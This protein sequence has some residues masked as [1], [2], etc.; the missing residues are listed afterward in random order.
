VGNVSTVVR[1]ADT[2]RRGTGPWTPAVHALLR[3]LEEV[4]FD[5][6]PR[7]RGIDEQGREILTYLSGDVPRRASPEIMMDW[8]SSS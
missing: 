1:I 4:G 7:V 3:Y 5:G 6:A 2:V 8:C